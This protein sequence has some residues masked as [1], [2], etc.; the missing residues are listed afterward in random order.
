[1]KNQL[2]KL[3]NKFE[4]RFKN[5]SESSKQGLFF[6]IIGGVNTILDFVILF[7]LSGIG[8]KK[9]HANIFST[10][11]TFV[12]SFS[13]NK[14]ITFKNQTKSKQELAREMLLFTAVTL[15][16]LWGIQSVIIS[17]TN[18]IFES[19]FQNSTIATI[20]SKGLATAF[21]LIWNFIMYKK[22]VFKNKNS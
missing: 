11:I 1:M 9:V 13:L 20:F 16:G 10:G 18:P 22:V 6:A 19:F 2:R 4:N 5:S 8:F 17:T 15:F 12:I 3:K 7:A 14:K 21:S